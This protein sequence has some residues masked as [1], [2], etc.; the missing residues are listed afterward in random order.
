MTADK[1]IVPTDRDRQH[2]KRMLDEFPGWSG[3]LNERRQ[4]GCDDPPGV[5][6]AIRQETERRAPMLPVV[7]EAASP[8]L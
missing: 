8:G 2:A 6:E 5:V 1:P 3:V 7:T 4:L